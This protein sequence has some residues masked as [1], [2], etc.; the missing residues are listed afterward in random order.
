MSM[1]RAVAAENERSRYSRMIS[2]IFLNAYFNAAASEAS[3]NF[4]RHVRV[5]QR[6]GDHDE[7]Y[8]LCGTGILGC[9][10]DA[11][12]AGEGAR[13]PRSFQSDTFHLSP[14][15][16]G[17]LIAQKYTRLKMSVGL[18]QHLAIHPDSVLLDFTCSVG[19]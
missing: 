4:R 1:H 2:K 6:S 11:S 3:D 15:L 8:D 5:K 9:A 10:E 13:A 7:E 18:G 19:G 16:Q 12:Y 17:K 14:D